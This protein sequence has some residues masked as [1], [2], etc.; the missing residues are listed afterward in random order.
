M[1]FVLS[2]F[3]KKAGRRRPDYGY[4]SFFFSQNLMVFSL[5]FSF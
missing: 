3:C 5:A 2:A 1:I 4:V